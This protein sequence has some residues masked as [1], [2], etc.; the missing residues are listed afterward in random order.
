MTLHARFTVWILMGCSALSPALASES[1]GGECLPRVTV[2][3]A[4]DDGPGTLRRAIQVVCPSGTIDFDLPF[5][6]SIAL[7]GDPL[8]IN[9]SLSIDGPGAELLTIGPN[10]DR[11]IEIGQASVVVRGVT[12]AGGTN[13]SS[14]GGIFN[15]GQLTL[16]DAV[17][18]DNFIDGFGLAEGAGIYNT[19]SL[20][21]E[22]VT[23]A[24]NT[25]TATFPAT[26][27]G[28]AIYNMRGRVLI[29]DSTLDRNEARGSGFSAVAALL[30]QGGEVT[31]RN[32][33]VSGNATTSTDLSTAIIANKSG[34]LI[35]I[36]QSTITNNTATG[37][38]FANVFASGGLITLR[39]SIAAGNTVSRTCSEP[40]VLR[41]LDFNV[42]NDGTCGPFEPGDRTT[43]VPALLPLGR[44]GGPTDTVAL[45]PDV[46]TLD[47]GDPNNC[48]PT[49]QRG[50]TRP[51][52]VGCDIGAFESQAVDLVLRKRVSVDVPVGAGAQ[53]R[54]TLEI[55][56]VGSS[57]TASA[58]ITDTLP[59]ET[60]FV[61][62]VTL[63]PPQ[64]DAILA[65]DAADFPTVARNVSLAPGETVLLTVPVAIAADAP[66]GAIVVNTAEV[67]SDEDPTPFSDTA[68]VETCALNAVV[69]IAGDERVPGS[70][71]QAVALACRN[72][73]V[74]FDLPPGSTIKL[75]R[76]PIVLDKPLTIRGPG[77]GLALQAVNSRHFTI[78]RTDAR[79]SDLSLIGGRAE[80]G[81]AIFSEFAGLELSNVV[82]AGNAAREAGGGIYQLGGSLVIDQSSFTSNRALGARG[83]GAI[84][85]DGGVLELT[86]SALTNNVVSEI[87]GALSM[88][89]GDFGP[90]TVSISSSTISANQ[91]G[92]SGGG[93]HVGINA[94]LTARSSTIANNFAP[95]GGAG[96]AN[97]GELSSIRLSN[98]I[99]AGNAP[100]PDCFASNLAIE[101]AGANLDSDDSCNLTAANDL[102]GVDPLLDALRNNGGPTLTN[103]LLPASPAIDMGTLAQC[104]SFDQRG[105]LRPQDGDGDLQERCDIG[106]FEVTAAPE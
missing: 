94:M 64:A 55:T 78:D 101:S 18:R 104:P 105:V 46:L 13:F 39:N 47:A 87:G 52:G 21:I 40:T 91:A 56:N 44:Y 92:I 99:V 80:Q 102:P 82:I 68:T 3:S 41:S 9:K 83:G 12:L 69:T 16:T 28:A 71:R 49:D 24:R 31:L 93:I 36:E 37:F 67:I 103:A 14:G 43:R 90:T 32:T 58:V 53:L 50:V 70:L 34:G 85:N 1:L 61:G 25:V 65:D 62:P 57:P 73:E 29:V 66:V 17:V 5:P 72:G 106:A 74:T 89:T 19:G 6:A 77:R 20:T 7:A 11:L 98:T 63:N 54:Y 15:R 30:N 38:L 60:I 33:T 4:Q 42:F 95:N 10:G 48:A 75:N 79:I 45:L 8:E 26:V 86:R 81:G 88:T 35:T 51:Q 97:D 84:F 22:R 100:A 2:V 76:G 27:E 96:I 59:P 23:I